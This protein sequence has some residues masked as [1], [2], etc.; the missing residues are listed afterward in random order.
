MGSGR[1]C[2]KH[3]RRPDICRAR[4]RVL[5][6]GARAR[7]LNQGARARVPEPGCQS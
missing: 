5:N 1:R 4:A 3:D 7:V 2:H 6:Q